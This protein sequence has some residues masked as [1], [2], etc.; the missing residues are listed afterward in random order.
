[1]TKSEMES[2]LGEWISEQRL[3]EYAPATLERY[4][5]SVEKFL[6]WCSAEE[7]DKDL[8]LNYKEWLTEVSDHPASI[9]TWIVCL[10]KYLKWLGHPELTLKKIK[11]QMQQSNEEVI[12]IADYKRLLRFAKRN[13]DM[14][15]YHIMKVLA[16]T[17]IRISE[18]RFFTVEALKS[19]YIDVKNKGKVRRIILRQDLRRELR[20]YARE[21]RIRSGYLF[22][23]PTAPGKMISKSTIWKRMQKYAGQ[24]RVKKSKVH[25]HSFRH[26]FAQVY[27]D[28]FEGNVT[29]LADILGHNSLETTRL[30]TRS[31]DAQKRHKMERMRFTK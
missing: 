21:N 1:M 4:R 31:S 25:P 7:I 30:Y 27:L 9:N 2:R 11:T 3:Q 18:L 29:E 20:R 23:S 15:M 8:M 22:P 10:N 26:L 13:N 28:T 17:G 5:Q 6:T 12:S 16:Y 19:N 24:A 14:E